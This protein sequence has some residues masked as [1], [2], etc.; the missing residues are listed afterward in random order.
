MGQNEGGNRGRE[1]D[2]GPK[3]LL[4]YARKLFDF[5]R[6]M[7]TVEYACKLFDFLHHM[8]TVEYDHKVF[9][10]IRYMF[11]VVLGTPSPPPPPHKPITKIVVA[12]IGTL[13]ILLTLLVITQLFF[14][15]WDTLLKF[16]IETPVLGVG[17]AFSNILLLVAILIV[18][19]LFCGFVVTASSENEQD[20][21][22]LMF[23]GALVPILFTFLVLFLSLFVKIFMWLIDLVP[24]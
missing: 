3:D 12:G 9:D 15:A 24:E 11:T 17:Y 14:G 6:Y 13:F 16:I 22:T 1:V 4:G 2:P 19:S 7:F 18:P 20:L 23:R 5:L 10:F 21:L 8:F